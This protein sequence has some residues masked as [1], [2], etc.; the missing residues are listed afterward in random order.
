[1]HGAFDVDGPP[2]ARD[3][4]AILGTALAKAGIDPARSAAA[5]LL[6]TRAGLAVAG[7]RA[8]VDFY[9]ASVAKLPFLVAAHAWMEQ[10][11]L[12][13]GA[14]LDRALDAMIRES[15]ND[16]TGH[17]VDCLT[18][19]TSGPEL[20]PAALRRFLARRRAINRYFR[21][22]PWPG[23]VGCNLMQKTFADGPYGRDRQARSPEAGGGNRLT[24]GGVAELLWSLAR[25]EAVTPARST[26]MLALLE[27]SLDPADRAAR[28][29]NQVD[30]FLGA[31]LPAGS[32][33]WSKAGW[34]SQ[35]RHDAAIVRLPSRC[36]FVLVAFTE[37]REA[38]GEILALPA[39]AAAVA[40]AVDG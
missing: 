37:G 22:A 31:G 7:H 34:T 29:Y 12:A 3:A 35:T 32:R 11:R 18:G 40:R 24:A 5:L 17:V 16:A 21:R 1:M 27:R 25:H 36:W 19:T 30:G 33:L 20:A 26:A 2:S 23:L 9:P 39:F 6:P 4:P 38:A 10:G 14:E 8:A 15:S 13:P 28:P